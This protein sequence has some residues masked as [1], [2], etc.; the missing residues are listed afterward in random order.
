MV[1]QLEPLDLLQGVL[2]G[3][4]AGTADRQNQPWPIVGA[5]QQCRHQQNVVPQG[6]QRGVLK[7]RGQAES[8]EPVDEVVPQQKQENVGLVGEE[9]T[10]GDAAQGVI[11]FELFD[12]PLDAARSL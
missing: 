10:G 7:F 1:L 9:G 8:L 11:A 5:T 2:P 4:L 12:Q 3:R 6:L